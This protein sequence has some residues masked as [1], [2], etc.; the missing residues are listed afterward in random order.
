MLCCYT[1]S[2]RGASVPI[3]AMLALSTPLSA[4]ADDRQRVEIPLADSADDYATTRQL[5]PRLQPDER[6]VRGM[7]RGRLPS[8]RQS[9]LVIWFDSKAQTITDPAIAKATGQL[10]EQFQPDIEGIP[11]IDIVVVRPFLSVFLGE[12]ALRASGG[13]WIR[14]GQS[15]H[16][17]RRPGHSARDLKIFGAVIHN[18]S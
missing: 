1:R 13:I 2:V 14:D 18:L 15:P 16:G 12:Y 10:F 11:T 8:T 3:A 17:W 9:V 4:T 6:G 5:I 7:W